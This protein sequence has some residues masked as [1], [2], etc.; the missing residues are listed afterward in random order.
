MVVQIFLTVLSCRPPLECLSNRHTNT[1]TSPELDLTI[2]ADTIEAKVAMKQYLLAE[3]ESLQ[4]AFTDYGLAVHRYARSIEGIKAS[5]VEIVE[6]QGQAHA[7]DETDFD[8]LYRAASTTS[9]TT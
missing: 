3:T 7:I 9:Q 1:Q 5:L 8:D 6:L 4:Q 2:G